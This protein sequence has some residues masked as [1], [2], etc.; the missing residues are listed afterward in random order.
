VD[1][2]RH[3]FSCLSHDHE[4]KRDLKKKKVKKDTCFGKSNKS[5]KKHAVSESTESMDSNSDS[6]SLNLPKKRGV[7]I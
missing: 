4:H 1:S 3:S 2:A 5:S 6:D 7:Q